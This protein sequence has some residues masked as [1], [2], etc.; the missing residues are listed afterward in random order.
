MLGTVGTDFRARKRGRARQEIVDA[1]WAL[2]R[3]DGVAALS[4]RD[5]AEEVGMRAPS[6]YTYFPSKNDLYDAM[7]A[8]GMRA[9]AD[10][11]QS[12]PVGRTPLE[13][14]KHRARTFLRASLEDP[15]RYE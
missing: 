5:L 15:V 8:D 2:A 12:S 7:F 4:L 14:L 11:I 10:Q 13:T 6:L 9:F 1:A 3:R